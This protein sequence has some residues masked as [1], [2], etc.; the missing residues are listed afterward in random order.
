MRKV[1]LSLAVICFT[2]FTLSAQ[3][4]T[5]NDKSETE[6]Q[7]VE[8]RKIE[9]E[10][11]AKERAA[12]VNQ[13]NPQANNPNAPVVSFDKMVH[14]Y[15][16]IAQNGDGNCEFIFTNTGKEPLVLSNVRSS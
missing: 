10:R 14:D 15:G 11:L 2:A 1:I 6:K 16:T 3:V 4:A 7:S 5:K 12:K 8:Q 9:Q 13:T